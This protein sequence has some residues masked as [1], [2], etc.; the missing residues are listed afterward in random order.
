MN[1]NKRLLQCLTCKREVSIS[2]EEL[3]YTVGLMIELRKKGCRCYIPKMQLLFPYLPDKI[4][5]K[6]IV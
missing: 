1:Q 2:N 3:I 5:G 6:I 4:E